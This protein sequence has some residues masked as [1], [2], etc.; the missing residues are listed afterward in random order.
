ML[1]ASGV[2]ENWSDT[3]VGVGTPLEK[4]FEIYFQ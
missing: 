1:N 2:K 4:V 3:S